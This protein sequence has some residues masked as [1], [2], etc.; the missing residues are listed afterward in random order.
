MNSP[1]VNIPEPQHHTL[2]EVVYEQGLETMFLLQAW[3][4]APLKYAALRW[5]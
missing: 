5:R 2:M 1:A 4:I 3:S